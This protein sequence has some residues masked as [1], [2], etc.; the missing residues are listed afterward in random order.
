MIWHPR[1]YTWH[2]TVLGADYAS[3]RVIHI[4]PET[5][6]TLFG[7]AF[8]GAQWQLVS[9][10][11]TFIGSIL[12][13]PD[14][15]RLVKG[16]GR[17]ENGRLDTGGTKFECVQ[18]EEGR[19]ALNTNGSFLS[20]E[21]DG[22]VLCERNF[23]GHWE[24]F[25]V[26]GSDVD[27]SHLAAFQSDT[28]FVLTACGR[29]DLLERAI[30]SFLRYNSYPIVQYIVV[31][32][33][34]DV[35]VNDHLKP[36]YAHLPITWIEEPRNRGLMS[37]MDDAYSRVKTKYIFHCEDD[38]EFY[39]AGFIEQSRAI[40][41]K[42]PAVMQVWIRA[43]N[44]TNNHPIE[45]DVFLATSEFGPVFFSL[46]G[47]GFHR[48]YYGYSTNPGL[49]RLSDYRLLGAHSP[50]KHEINVSIAYHKLLFRAAIIRGSGFVRHLGEGRHIHDPFAD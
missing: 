13:G 5:P 36:K 16:M 38:W 31:E 43:E 21:S 15:V 30:D 4:D 49:R 29:P 22:T 18:L 23:P 45:N 37:C 32:D 40:L 14:G 25:W 1:V 42:S 7:L 39:R 6:S 26:P 24:S 9:W 8:D 33:S 3:G 20:A 47:N 27:L 28:T 41:E 10:E 11:N 44:D 35:S 2:G 12:C 50:Y 48:V 19:F 34:G 46:M 17:I